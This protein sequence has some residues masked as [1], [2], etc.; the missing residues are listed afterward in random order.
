MSVQL[1]SDPLGI[2]QA[3]AESSASAKHNVG[4]KAVASDGRIFRYVKAGGSNLV[5]GNLLQSPARVANHQAC[6]ALAASATYN[7][8]G[9]QQILVTLGATAA[10]ANQYA[11][12]LAIVSVTPG[13]GTQ[14][15]IVSHPAAGSGQTLLLT[16][17]IPLTV[18][19]TTSSRVDLCA[20][21]YNGVI[22][23]PTTLTGSPVGVCT[24]VIAAGEFGWIQRSGIA[25][26]LT[27]GTPAVGSLV[28]APGSTAGAVKIDPADAAVVPIGTMHETG[29]NGAV[30]AVML[31]LE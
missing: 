25:G 14:Y 18:A 24:Y 4:E 26:V 3:Y 19:L 2:G 15:P 9:T 13:L 29:V 17:G 11:G 31:A 16:V 8:I 12:G 23:S 10:T 28:V 1:S 27:D 30:K 7:A 21:P 5:A 22:Q 6:A 20:N